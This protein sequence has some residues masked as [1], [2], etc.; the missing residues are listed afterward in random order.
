MSYKKLRKKL[1]KLNVNLK[2]RNLQRIITSREYKLPLNAPK[3]SSHTDVSAYSDKIWEKVKSLINAED[4]IKTIAEQR[5]IKTKTTQY[6]DTAT[7][8]LRKNQFILRHR[9][10]HEDNNYKLTLKYRSKDRYLASNI[11]IADTPDSKVKFEEDIL[12]NTHKYS[13]STSNKYDS[14]QE[15]TTLE[16]IFKLL[17]MQI[18]LNIPST[19]ELSM[20]NDF[21]AHEITHLLGDV[22]FDSGHKVKFCINYWF[23]KEGIY[24]TPLIAELSFDY[25]LKNNTQKIKWPNHY[26]EQFHIP[27]VK[28]T[29]TIFKALQNVPDLI[30]PN[31]NT[32]THYA[33]N[34]SK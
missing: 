18:S 14:V 29:D 19:T 9:K 5:D 6:I 4:G 27:T 2:D 21:Q 31:G 33:Y 30:N 32:K 23:K 26:L 10:N 12:L 1:G 25:D 8:T 20:V 24:D 16:D 17:P 22:T 3:F 7:Q 34:A 13:L 11:Q 15:I 28:A